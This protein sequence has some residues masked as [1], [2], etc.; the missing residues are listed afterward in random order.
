[1][2]EMGF[3]GPSYAAPS[4]YKDDQECINFRPEID[5]LKQAGQRGVVALYPTPGLS[6]FSTLPAN[7]EVRGMRTLSGGKYMVVV[8]GSYVYYLDST[9]AYTQIGQLLTT[10]GRVGIADNGLQVMITDGANRYS[11]YISTTLTG[12][13]NGVISGNQV[14][15]VSIISGSLYVGQAITGTGVPANTIITGSSNTANGTGVYGLNNSVSNGTLTGITLNAAGTGYTAPPSVQVSSPIIGEVATVT[16][17]SITVVSSTLGSGGTGYTVGDVLTGFGG[18]Y[19]TACQIKVLTVSSGVIATFQVIVNG[20]Y[21]TAPTSPVTFLGGT[22]KG[23]TVTL[24]FGL[25][26]DYTITNAGSFY[27]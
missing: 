17:N 11:W 26:N 15:V 14:N 13:F 27:T 25:N 20:V 21:Q 10:T 6:L 8:C 22:G 12:S 18:A 7:A 1:M 2:P 5:P 23:A 9:G 24:T 16:W 4:I 19:T 3:V